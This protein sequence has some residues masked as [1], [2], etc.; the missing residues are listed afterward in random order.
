M[1]QLR[2]LASQCV[3]L[4]RSVPLALLS[5]LKLFLR[6]PQSSL[7]LLDIIRSPHPKRRLRL[8][9][10]LLPFLGGGIYL[11]SNSVSDLKT[12][13]SVG[14]QQDVQASDLLYVFG[15]VVFGFEPHSRC[16]LQR[17]R[18]NR[19][20]AMPGS[21]GRDRGLSRQTFA[22]ITRSDLAEDQAREPNGS[23]GASRRSNER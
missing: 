9:I 14:A 22:S 8:S 3:A 17:W 23:D 5:S 13:K 19:W 11:L 4:V 20:T 7:E 2:D 16:H 15:L 21:H 6:F 12:K 10:T 1:F 18:S